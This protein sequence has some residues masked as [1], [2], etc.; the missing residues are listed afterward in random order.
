MSYFINN[1][2]ITITHRQFNNLFIALYKLDDHLAMGYVNLKIDL[3]GV[4]EKMA[5]NH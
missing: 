4:T 5:K 2:L 1:F 3:I